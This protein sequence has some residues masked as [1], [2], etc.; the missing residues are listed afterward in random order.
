[1][2]FNFSKTLRKNSSKLFKFKFIRLI[3]SKKIS[4]NPILFKKSYTD[5]EIL[6]EENNNKLQVYYLNKYPNNKLKSLRNFDSQ[7]QLKLFEDAESCNF[8][9][10]KM[11]GQG[12]QG[13]VYQLINMNE[14]IK[15]KNR[16]I[17][18]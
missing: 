2:E 16:V 4:L 1:M 14:K 12:G 17:A 18:L 10:Y 15:D 5:E 11:I 8:I 7:Q 6:I 13:N 9:I 3:M